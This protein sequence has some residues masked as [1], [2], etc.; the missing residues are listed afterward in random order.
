MGIASFLLGENNP[1]AQWAG[2]NQNTLSAIGAGLAQGQNLQGGL[3]AGL[4]A[5]PQAKQ[6]DQAA[7]EK[8]KAEKLAE[9]QANATKNWLSANHPDLAQMVDAGMPVSEAWQAAMKRMEPQQGD[10]SE[11]DQRYAAGQQ[12]GLTGDELN[13]F[14]LTGAVP[15]TSRTNV[16]YGV[17]PIYGTDTTTGKTGMG[18]QGSDGSFKLVDTGDFQPLGPYDL[19]AQ[20]AAGT[21]FGKGT[22][23]AQFDVPAAELTMNQTLE[24]INAIRAEKKGMDEQFGNIL[25]VPQQMTAAWP[26]S[27]KAKFQVAVDRATNRAFL[28][29]REVLRGG[30]QITDFESKKAESAITNMQLA[31]EKGDKAQFEAALVQF[32]QAVRDGYAKLKTQAGAIPGYGGGQQPPAALT[33]GNVTSSG[34]QWS[35]EP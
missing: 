29:A 15:G 2:Q 14:A 10:Q 30:G 7:A 8:L 24:A 11:F 25:G 20:K 28:E 23:G 5:V 26:G 9:N 16:T 35:V 33:N 19:N 27:D 17:T 18:V 3:A 4:A 13:T 12:Y 31:M 6:L 32:E 34:V 21:A 1:F 22:G